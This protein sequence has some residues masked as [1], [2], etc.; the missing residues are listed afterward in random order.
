MLGVVDWI[1]CVVWLAA[2][3]VV[4]QTRGKSKHIIG[5]FSVGFSVFSGIL[6]LKSGS[7]VFIIGSIVMNKITGI[8]TSLFYYF[9]ANI[10]RYERFHETSNRIYLYLA[11]IIILWLVLGYG[12]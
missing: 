3:L 8:F 1:W 11:G 2:G 9:G 7:L 10:S 12:L 5:A 6:L 4:F